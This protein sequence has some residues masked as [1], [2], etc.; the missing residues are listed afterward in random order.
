MEVIMRKYLFVIGLFLLFLFPQSILAEA[1]PYQP[2]LRTDFTYE[3]SLSLNEEIEVSFLFANQ[4]QQGNFKIEYDSNVF[5]LVSSS[6]VDS[7]RGSLEDLSAIRVEKIT[8]ANESGKVTL[9]FKVKGLLG[10][11]TIKVTDIHFDGN[12]ADDVEL[13]FPLPDNYNKLTALSFSHGVLSPEFQEDVTDY[14]LQIDPSTMT[15]LIEGVLFSNAATVE[16]LGEVAVEIGKTHLITVTS[17]AGE[18]RT[19]T[20]H[21]VENTSLSHDAT[22]KLLIPTNG[23]LPFRS[24]TYSY[25]IDVSSD[26]T[27]F[28][29]KAIPKSATATVSVS[30]N[31]SLNFGEN[32][33]VIVVTSESGNTQ[34]YKITVNRNEEKGLSSDATLKS[35]K[36]DGVSFVFD[37]NTF[38]Y[39][40]PRSS[41]ENLKIEA[42]SNNS[43]AKVVIQGNENLQVGSEISIIVTAEN[44][45]NQVYKLRISEATLFQNNTTWTIVGGIVL[46]LGVLSI[47]GVVIYRASKIKKGKKRQ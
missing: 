38:E 47:I 21:F 43:N 44:G 25:R 4:Y 15:V 8:E 9:R 45:M 2:E 19:Y 34:E 29:V 22:L 31:G 17:A 7:W 28:D 23:Y 46:A 40:I 5:E 24:D 36:I 26:V 12:T 1:V 20:I 35:L 14:N 33:I 41:F 10:S 37:S 39:T 30:G 3:H 13:S 6:L 11:S 18:K 16:G 42:L 27:S 32:N